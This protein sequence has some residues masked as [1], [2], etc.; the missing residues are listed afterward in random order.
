MRRRESSKS[1]LFLLEMM[2]SI[3]FFAIAASVC[4]QV[5]VKANMLSRKAGELNMAA[6]IAASAAELLAMEDGKEKT[7]LYYDEDWM[8]CEADE[9]EY[10]LEMPQ[11]QEEG[12]RKAQICVKDSEGESI[13]ELEAAHYFPQ[14]TGSE[15][16]AGE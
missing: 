8:P 3:L 6:G 1:S 15:V 13:Y 16:S 10:T 4:I 5:F 11:T 7:A 12:L 14:K 2:I 9:A